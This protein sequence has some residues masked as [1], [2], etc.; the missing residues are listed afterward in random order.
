MRPTHLLLIGMLALVSTQAHAL[1]C[2]NDLVREGM[3]RYEVR[4]R[5]GDPDDSYVRYETVYRRNSR[6]EQVAY[7]I[8]F[9]EWIYDFPSNRLDRRL[10]FVNGYLFKEEILDAD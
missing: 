6:D 2:G 5:C 8:E 3:S 10:I 9:E 7:D 1:R 4:K